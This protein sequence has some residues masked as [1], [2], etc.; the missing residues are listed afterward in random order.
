MHAWQI[1]AV[2][3]DQGLPVRVGVILA[4]DGDVD[5]VEDPEWGMG[6]EESTVAKVIR[7]KLSSTACIQRREMLFFSCEIHGLILSLIW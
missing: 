7:A 6:D 2:I 5:A 1:A 3:V 4:S